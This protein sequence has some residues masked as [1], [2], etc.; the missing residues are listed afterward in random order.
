MILSQPQNY[1]D[2]IEFLLYI[3][4]VASSLCRILHLSYLPIT[5]IIASKKRKLSRMERSHYEIAST[6]FDFNSWMENDSTGRSTYFVH[7]KSRIRHPHLFSTVS[8]DLVGGRC[9]LSED[10]ASSNSINAVFNR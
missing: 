1:K 8:I 10:A 5:F 4:K 9:R 2:S 7:R 6:I 3:L